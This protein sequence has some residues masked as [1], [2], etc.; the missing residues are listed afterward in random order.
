VTAGNLPVKG[1]GQVGIADP[2]NGAIM[3]QLRFLRPETD[4]LQ[5]TKAKI[6]GQS[7]ALG[8]VFGQQLPSKLFFTEL[9]SGAAAVQQVIPEESSSNFAAGVAEH[10]TSMTHVHPLHSVF[11]SLMKPD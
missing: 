3:P 10:G 5:E 11:A 7:A 1:S 4:G 9:P 8:N 6:G 2:M